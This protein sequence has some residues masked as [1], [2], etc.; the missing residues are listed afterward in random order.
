MYSLKSQRKDNFWRLK[1][2]KFI[3]NFNKGISIS[4]ECECYIIMQIQYTKNLT[5]TRFELGTTLS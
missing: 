5:P 2:V 3:K 4:F 1:K